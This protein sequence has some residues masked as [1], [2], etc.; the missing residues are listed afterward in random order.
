MDRG[1]APPSPSM[2]HGNSSGVILSWDKGPRQHRLGP[3]AS[4]GVNGRITPE[5]EVVNPPRAKQEAARWGKTGFP[6]T[7]HWGYGAFRL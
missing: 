4:R 7:S 1:L 5:E 2:L 6:V 3:E